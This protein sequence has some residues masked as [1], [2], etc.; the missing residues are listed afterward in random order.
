MLIHFSIDSKIQKEE[1][2]KG[3]V[4][5]LTENLYKEVIEHYNNKKTSLAKQSLPVFQNVKLNQGSHV[6]NV[7]VPLTDGKKQVNVLT[8]LDKAIST[9]AN[10]II[11]KYKNIKLQAKFNSN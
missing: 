8:N 1:L 10:P 5:Q 2:E 11:L 4:N 6:V 7:I 3:D 9:K